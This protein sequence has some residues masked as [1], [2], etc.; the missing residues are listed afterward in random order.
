MVYVQDLAQKQPAGWWQQFSSSSSSSSSS[1]RTGRANPAC[2]RAW[3]HT[4]FHFDAW[5]QLLLLLLLLLVVV[6]DADVPPHL[7]ADAD[8]PEAAQL[9]G[10]PHKAAAVAKRQAFVSADANMQGNHQG[11][12]VKGH[13]PSGCLQLQVT[14]LSSTNAH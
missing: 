5:W 8:P 10:A 4:R 9:P 1:S 14:A 13:Q 2:N 11:W 3:Q 12:P 6:V 7:L